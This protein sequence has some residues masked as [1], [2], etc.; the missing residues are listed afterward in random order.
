MGLPPRKHLDNESLLTTL[1]VGAI[2]RNE[3]R[4]ELGLPRIEGWDEIVGGTE[5][6]PRTSI[7]PS[8]VLSFDPPLVMVD[9][10][11][12]VKKLQALQ[13]GY[14]PGSVDL[15]KVYVILH[16]EM[17]EAKA[18]GDIKTAC[19]F[20]KAVKEISKLED[21]SVEPLPANK[22]AIPSTIKA[23]DVYRMPGRWPVDLY[24][25]AK[26]FYT[27]K[28]YPDPPN[29]RQTKLEFLVEIVNSLTSTGAALVWRVPGDLV[30]TA[31]AVVMNVTRSIPQPASKAF[32]E[33]CYA[34]VLG[35]GLAMN[36]VTAIP[37]GQVDKLIS[38]EPIIR[39]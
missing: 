33:G 11:K 10:E 28:G 6:P 3:L 31:E 24:A 18:R 13:P 16:L 26:Q 4:E 5:R 25:V 8:A 9:Y 29:P 27:D 15:S 19:A 12:A 21:K 37:A 7:S 35:T 17:K 30:V 34:F 32:P 2:T 20:L 1:I 14:I 23:T 39:K 36:G 22:D 38:P